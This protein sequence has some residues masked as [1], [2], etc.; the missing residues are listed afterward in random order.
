MYE[1]S[2]DG[3]GRGRRRK[4]MGSIAGEEMAVGGGGKEERILV[5][6]R[7]RPLNEKE[8]ERNDA[9]D[10]EYTTNNTIISKNGPPVSYTF[11]E[12]INFISGFQKTMKNLCFVLM[13]YVVR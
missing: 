8:I 2:V 13:H 7:I 1:F 9:T 5:S 10:W 6:V 4:E 3:V 11:G 12:F